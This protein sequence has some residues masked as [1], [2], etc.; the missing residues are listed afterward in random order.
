MACQLQGICLECEAFMKH[1]LLPVDFSSRDAVAAQCATTLAKRFSS[2]LTMLH[3]LPAINMALE[4]AGGGGGFTVQ[5]V[6]AHQKLETEQKLQSFLTGEFQSLKVNRVLAE[7]DPAETIV[8]YAQ[9]NNVD[10]IVMPTS[11]CGAFRRFL[12]GSVA[13][14]VLHD[15]RCPVL[16]TQHTKELQPDS[17]WAVHNILCAVQLEPGDDRLIRCAREFTSACGATLSIVHAMT[18]LRPHPE[19]YYLESDM[20][21]LLAR[22]VRDKIDHILSVCGILNAPIYIEAGISVAGVLRSVVQDHHADLV[23]IHRTF[24]NQNHGRVRAESFGI[25]G[26]SPCP[27]L[28]I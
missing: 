1:I 12:L 9:T 4:L 13:A 24:G 14:K 15:S 22:S 26:E 10:L 7:G 3:V 5:E 27:V 20:G 23:V 28:S 21:R 17:I 19:T 11:G 16:T 25:I 6:L 18:S 8:D 2:S